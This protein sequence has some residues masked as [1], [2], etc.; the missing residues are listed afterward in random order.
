MID[1]I[2][3]DDRRPE[4]DVDGRQILLTRQVKNV[5][6]RIYRV[7]VSDTIYTDNDGLTRLGSGNHWSGVVAWMPFPRP[8]DGIRTEA[9]RWSRDL[10]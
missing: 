9:E 8:F 3:I 2:K 1:W 7:T 4:P 5:N 6:G 10:S